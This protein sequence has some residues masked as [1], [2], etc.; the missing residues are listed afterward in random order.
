LWYTAGLW[1]FSGLKV[2]TQ[3]FFSLKDTRTP[4]WISLFAVVVNL[5]AG[6]LLMNPMKHGGLALATTIAA[7]LNFLILFLILIRRIKWFEISAFLA[8]IAR[9]SAASSIMGVFLLLMRELGLWSQGIN[10]KNLAVLLACVM[11]GVGVYGICA[12]VLKC[13]QMKSIKSVLRR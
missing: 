12:Y 1:A 2:V 8:S 11:G 6:I 5:G 3:A 10:W 4:L 7:A 9:I 13:E